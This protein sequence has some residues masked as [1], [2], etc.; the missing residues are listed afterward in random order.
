VNGK[1]N[2]KLERQTRLSLQNSINFQVAL[3]VYCFFLLLIRNFVRQW[4]FKDTSFS[5]LVL[6]AKGGEI[7]AKAAGSTT[8]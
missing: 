7:K 5:I 1:G 4:G 8:I 3:D 2:G 6:N